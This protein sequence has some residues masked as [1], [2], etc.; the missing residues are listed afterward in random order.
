MLRNVVGGSG[1]KGKKAALLKKVNSR[2]Y[3]NTNFGQFFNGK[4]YDKLI[5][6]QASIFN[7]V[8]SVRN[9]HPEVMI[10]LFLSS[11]VK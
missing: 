4:L 7:V 2:N 3:E 1:A 5:R 11:E 10:C 9:N 8:I 6:R